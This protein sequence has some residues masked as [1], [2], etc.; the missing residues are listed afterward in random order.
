LSG[1]IDWTIPTKTQEAIAE[2]VGCSFQYVSKVQ[3]ELSTSGKL[4]LP[5]T[6]KGKDGKERPTQYKPAHVHRLR[7]A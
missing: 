3:G 5:A 1:R 7:L 4:I 6:R 2:H